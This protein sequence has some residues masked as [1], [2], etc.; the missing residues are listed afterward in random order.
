MAGGDPGRVRLRGQ[1]VHRRVDRLQRLV[2]FEEEVARRGGS[3]RCPRRDVEV[4]D[5]ELAAG[6]LV[7]AVHSAPFVPKAA[8]IPRG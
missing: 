6:N 4:D 2:R 5:H 1:P 8:P 3:P 7:L